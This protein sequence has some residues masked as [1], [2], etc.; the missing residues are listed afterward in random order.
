MRADLLCA[1]LERMRRLACAAAVM[2]VTLWSF[3]SFALAQ[4]NSE[5]TVRSNA[6]LSVGP[7]LSNGTLDFAPSVTLRAHRAKTSLLLSSTAVSVSAWIVE[8]GVG[9]SFPSS[10]KSS[11][12]LSGTA[13]LSTLNDGDSEFLLGTRF[14]VEGGKKTAARAEIRVYGAFADTFELRGAAQFGI[15]LRL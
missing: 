5:E 4:T 7:F 14:G 10:P 13:G 11:V 8:A 6:F 15:V 1:N 12:D 2:V 3:P 9:R